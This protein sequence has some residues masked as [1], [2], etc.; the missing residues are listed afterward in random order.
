[1]AMEAPIWLLAA[2][3]KWTWMTNP[4]EPMPELPGNHSVLGPEELIDVDCKVESPEHQGLQL[5]YT[6]IFPYFS[7][8][9]HSFPYPTCCMVLEYLPTPQE[10]PSHVGV[11]FQHHGLHLGMFSI[12]LIFTMDN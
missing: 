8:C 1:M 10:S 3:L 7:I 9:F 4:G 12:L 6:N 11:L 2:I 5:T